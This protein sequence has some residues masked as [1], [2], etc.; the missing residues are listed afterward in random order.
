MTRI[1]V[2]GKASTLHQQLMELAAR[3]HGVVPAIREG[4]PWDGRKVEPQ[5]KDGFREERR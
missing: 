2:I 4:G 5:D 3:V 1:I